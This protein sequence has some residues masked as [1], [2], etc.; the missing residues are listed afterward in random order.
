MRVIII[1]S[2]PAGLTM[3]HCLHRAGVED[4]VILERRSDP[5]DPSGAGLG[6]WPQTFRIMDQL[7]LIDRF[8]AL[9][10]PMKRSVHLDPEGNVIYESNLFEYATEK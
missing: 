6:F 8:R 7:G 4:F 10:P 9:S 2:G 5:V 1:G 3:G